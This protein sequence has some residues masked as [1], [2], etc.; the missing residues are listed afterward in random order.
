MESMESMLFVPLS[1]RPFKFIFQQLHCF[2]AA[3]KLFHQV[4]EERAK[5]KASRLLRI[6]NGGCFG[7]LNLSHVSSCEIFKFVMSYMKK[8]KTK[9]N[10]NK[11]NTQTNSRECAVCGLEIIFRLPVKGYLH[12]QITRYNSVMYRRHSLRNVGP[13]LWGKL[14]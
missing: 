7:T 14:S 13:K 1:L 9:Q 11:K 4:K 3:A 5:H 10:K 2:F 6:D 8:A 12:N